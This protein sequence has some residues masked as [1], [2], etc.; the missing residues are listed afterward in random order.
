M[1]VKK[2]GVREISAERVALLLKEAKSCAEANPSRSK[3][4]CKLAFSLVKRNRSRLE[5]E[6]KVAFCRS[7]FLYWTPGK[8]VKVVFDKHNKRVVYSC[9]ECGSQR[10]FAYKPPRAKSARKT[11][12]A[13]S[14]Q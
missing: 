12:P 9:S 8:T 5:N 10:A 3:S 7:C 4:Y 2:T 6:Q 11:K 13:R 14:R 1:G